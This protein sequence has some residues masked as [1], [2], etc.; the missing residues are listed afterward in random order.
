[1]NYLRKLLGRLSHVSK[2]PDAPRYFVACIS[3]TGDVVEV[4]LY[5]QT[6][7]YERYEIVWPPEW[8][9]EVDEKFLMERGFTIC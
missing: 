1:M 2:L 4:D 8:P 9:V 7:A 6:E 5:V 3:G